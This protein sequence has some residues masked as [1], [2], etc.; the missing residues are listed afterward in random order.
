MLKFVSEKEKKPMSKELRLQNSQNYWKGLAGVGK[1]K[2]KTRKP[3]IKG[4]K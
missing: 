2:V 1:K 4:N 3:P